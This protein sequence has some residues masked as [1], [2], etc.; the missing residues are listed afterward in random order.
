MSD[1]FSDYIIQ[2]IIIGCDDF[3][4]IIFSI[5]VVRR[6]L[7]IKNDMNI[8]NKYLLYS[9]M[10][11]SQLQKI[12]KQKWTFFSLMKFILNILISFI[13]VLYLII[14]PLFKVMNINIGIKNNLLIYFIIYY[15]YNLISMITWTLSTI[16][17]YKEYRIY[18]DQTWNSIR[19]FWVLNNII[20][21]I[22]FIFIL[23]AFFFEKNISFEFLINKILFILNCSIFFLSCILSFLTIFHPYDVSIRKKS[24][25]IDNIKDEL[26]KTTLSIGIQDELLDNSE[27]EFTNEEDLSFQNLDTIILE[28]PDNDGLNNKLYNIEIKI[29]TKDFKE[30]TFSLK[31]QKIKH[32]RNKLPMIVCN[33]N[34]II[35]KY[36]KNKNASKEIINLIKEAYNISL[37]L[38]P[39]RTSFTGDKK[40]TNLLSHLYCEII[41]KDNQFLLDLLNFLQIKCD[42]LINSLKN[43]FTSI[44]EENPN[45]EQEIERIDT[46]GSIFDNFEDI[47]IN[48][49]SNINRK[50]SLEDSKNNNS[51]LLSNMDKNNIISSVKSNKIIPIKRSVIPKDNISFA[52]FLNK[53]IIYK[54]FLTIQIISYE[55]TS[56]NLNFILK[57]I[58]NNKK[59]KKEIFL[60]VNVF[61]LHDIIYDDE[62]SSFL[63]DNY[64]NI[65]DKKSNSKN[66]MEELFNNYLNN[67][68]YYDEKL[69][70]IFKLNQL[71]TLNK[72]KFHEEIIHKFF[73]EKKQ[74]IGLFKDDIRQF[75]FD[76]KL[77]IYKNNN[78]IKSLINENNIE[79]T[80][81]KAN[82]EEIISNDKKV[83]NCKINIIKLYL[84]IENMIKVLTQKK[85]PYNELSSNLN[86]IK[87]YVGKLLNIIYN[88]PE[89]QLKNIK[90]YRTN[91]VVYGEQKINC[92][93]E[94]FEKKYSNAKIKINNINNELINELNKEIKNLNST[95]NSLLNKPN[96]K[97]ALYFTSFR[98]IIEFNSLY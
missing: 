53:I 18:K 14:Y 25:E 31:I 63:I 64:E 62:L 79:I 24:E 54:H 69:Y 82:T 34:E 59:D 50:I 75:L 73:E 93:I 4:K 45:V 17:Y 37:T 89:D 67:I 51:I 86:N 15:S 70:N 27:S 88:V 98:E 10:D 32:K 9:N 66:I 84:L 56:N 7:K 94:E 49:I 87:I 46:L 5:I 96:L 90:N 42:D 8:E 74:N 40:A 71:I 22:E 81:S 60:Q 35:L 16:L 43:N 58:N 21:L 44:F 30:L 1:I 72:D 55:E 92:L 29:K 52:S 39:Q 38:N 20:T 97:Y 36:Y 2:I 33:F 68:F 28:L 19:I 13:Y 12:D 91:K 41:K 57:T 61:S 47:N 83:I 48:D 76:I 6:L 26:N 65:N 95:L 85:L 77:K 11:G 80:I 78:D 23:I 3:F